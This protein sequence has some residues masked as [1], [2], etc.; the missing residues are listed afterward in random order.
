[1]KDVFK[2]TGMKLATSLDWNAKKYV[3][4]C[5]GDTELIHRY[6]R[7]KMKEEI[8]VRNISTDVTDSVND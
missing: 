3:K 5:K 1:M 6:S 2:V 8:R 4:R 7:R